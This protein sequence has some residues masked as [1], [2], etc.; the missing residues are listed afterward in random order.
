M[1]RFLK[2][3]QDE[4]SHLRQSGIQELLVCVAVC[5][6]KYAIELKNSRVLK[7]TEFRRA[8]NFPL[9]LHVNNKMD[10]HMIRET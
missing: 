9:E 2:Q 6:L 3:L 8:G 1:Q 10:L 4:L 7:S 5:L